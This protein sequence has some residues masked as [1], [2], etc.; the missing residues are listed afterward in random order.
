MTGSITYNIGK[1]AEQK[2]IEYLKSSG[3]FI[4]NHRYKTLEGEIDII[5]SIK[6]TLVFCEVKSRSKPDKH[7][8]EIER[9]MQRSCLVA[10]TFLGRN[11]H[12]H[13]HNCRFDLIFICK[14]KIEHMQNIWE[15]S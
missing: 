6:N 12:F 9:K 11:P 5:A 3:Y 4:L 1:F 7:N 13:G 14:G 8:I 15:C 10:N 2:A